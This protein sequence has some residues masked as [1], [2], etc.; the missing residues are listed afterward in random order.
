MILFK[1]LF[2]IRCLGTKRDPTETI[3]QRD[4]WHEENESE[5]DAS[6]AWRGSA[7]QENGEQAEPTD[8]KCVEREP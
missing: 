5:T 4:G 2:F 7:Q 3:A 1:M 8:G 6:N